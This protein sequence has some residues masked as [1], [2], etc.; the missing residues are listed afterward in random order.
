M[1]S[2][3]RI[4]KAVLHCDGESF[5]TDT[6]LENKYMENILV[7]KELTEYA[8]DKDIVI[9]IENL[10]KFTSEVD[11]L[12]YIVNSVGGDN[13][14]ICLDT[15][16]LNLNSKDQEGFIKRAGKYLKALHIAD[17]EGYTDQHMMPFG[18]GNVDFLK[19]M[20]ALKE[21]K[22]DGLFN[23]EIPGERNCP[24]EIRKY[25]IDYIKN[26]YEYLLKRSVNN[27]DTKK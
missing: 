23:L 10:R 13:I 21:V 6:S 4:S 1:F 15:G 11:E 22:Y 26:V 12:L 3:I 18:K 25:K 8:K 24:L 14:G 7:L 9:C 27:T 5:P 19:V 20:Q 17:N 2:E 16:H